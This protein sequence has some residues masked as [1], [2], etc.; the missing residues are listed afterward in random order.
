MRK[1]L[2]DHQFFISLITSYI[3]KICD[4]VLANSELRRQQYSSTDCDWPMHRLTHT[5][6][7]PS[8]MAN[9]AR[10]LSYPDHVF[11]FSSITNNNRKAV[12]PSK[13]IPH[14][15]ILIM[16]YLVVHHHWTN[17]VRFSAEKYIGYSIFGCVSICF[18]SDVTWHMVHTRFSTLCKFLC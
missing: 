2:R 4:L 12:W 15:L 7:K 11:P 13:T 8:S 6:S 1:N 9:L 17:P 16:F 14:W 5:L 3:H 10:S 18:S